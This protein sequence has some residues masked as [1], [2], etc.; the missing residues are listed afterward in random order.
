MTDNLEEA[1]SSRKRNVLNT[2][3]YSATVREI[4]SF[5]S[6]MGDERGFIRL[7][8]NFRILNKYSKKME[9]FYAI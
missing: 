9:I 4:F 6:L 2:E 5:L 1:R 3:Q 8:G 7:L